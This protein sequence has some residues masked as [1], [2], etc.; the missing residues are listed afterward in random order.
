MTPT[1]KAKIILSEAFNYSE[2]L[3][4]LYSGGKDSLVLCDLAHKMGFKITLLLFYL[5][6]DLNIDNKKIEYALNKWHIHKVLKY[7]SSL[8]LNYLKEGLFCLPDKTIKKKYKFGDLI[9]LAKKREQIDCFSCIGFKKSDSFHRHIMLKTYELEGI[10]RNSKRIYPLTDF[11]KDDILSY[12]TLNNIVIPSL[13]AINGRKSTGVTFH[14]TNLLYLKKYYPS[15]F[16]K[17]KKDFPLIEA[18][19][20]GTIEI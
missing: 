8:R 1:S 3:L 10:H 20:H 18:S 9:D 11:R 5:A 2:H 13:Q 15:D 7:P 19:L 16:D 6:P 12:C 14:P 4:I 17:L